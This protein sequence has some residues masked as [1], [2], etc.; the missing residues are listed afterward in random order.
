MKRLRVSDNRRYLV[1][2]DGSPFFWLGD[3]AWEIFHRLAFE[4]AEFYCQNRQQKGFTLFHAVV[5]AE[6]DGLGTPNRH[7]DLP[8]LHNDPL[9]P[10]EAYFQQVDRV[11]ALGAK[12]GLYV[13][14]VPTWGDKIE[15]LAHGKGPIIFNPDN[16]RQYGEWIGR[17][18]RDVENLVW[19]NGGDR[20]GGGANTA[21]W[22]ALGEGIKAQDPNHLMTF[23]P[24]GG[25]DGY[26]SSEWFHDAPWLDFN[27]S[28]SGH[29]RHHLPNHALISRDYARTPIKPCLDGEPRY[30]DHAVNWKPLENGWFDDYDAR[31]AAYWALFAGAFGHTYGCHPVWQFRSEL[32]EPISF[33]RRPWQEALDLPGAY[34]MTHV[35]RLMES[36]PM[37]SRVPD[38]SLV[39]DARDGGDHIRATRGDGY[40]FVYLPQGGSV[41]VRPGVLTGQRFQTWWFDPR[42]GIARNAGVRDRADEM[43]F[44]ASSV[45]L[46]NDWVLVLDDVELGYLPPGSLFPG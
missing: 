10:N 35:R 46:G 28:Q 33:A 22:N 30:E 11:I 7:G 31:Q 23:H 37:L 38:Q 32:Y 39:T 34:Q 15:L 27:L 17:R 19:F 3:T 25:G 43:E 13:G 18:Y 21:I 42:T 2:E 40:A 20:S 14:L 1:F 26:S 12:H 41:T 6:F 44:T 29:V 45:G 36:R 9:Q 4:E 24:W 8:L 16:A 5:L